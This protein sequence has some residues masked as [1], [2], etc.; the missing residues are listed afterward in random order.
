MR[1]LKLIILLISLISC[2]EKNNPTAYQETKIQ[3]KKN[4]EK[5]KDADFIQEAAEINLDAITLSH[6]AQQ[7]SINPKTKEIATELELTHVKL[8]SELKNLANK[9]SLSVP[10]QAKENNSYKKLSNKIAADFDKDYFNNMVINYEYAI[11]RFEYASNTISD[12][13]IRLWTKLAVPVLRKNL[14]STLILQ[15]ESNK[16]NKLK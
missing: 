12:P 8:Y 7:N 9:K 15:A 5:I 1:E 11:K 14:G 2:R 6:L 13:E 16:K 4:T 10:S 3:S